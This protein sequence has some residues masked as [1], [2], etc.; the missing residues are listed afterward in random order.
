LNATLHTSILTLFQANL[1]A[2]AFALLRPVVETLYRVHLVIMGEP[3][4]LTGLRT[5]KF[6]LSF[7]RD[8]QKIDDHFSLGGQ[9]K[10]LV[11][12]MVSLLHSFT[13]V[14]RE[15][16]RRQFNGSN[17]EANYPEAEILGVTGMSMMAKFMIATRIIERFQP[18]A[19]QEVL[20]LFQGFSLSLT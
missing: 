2:G 20:A 12:R 11:D 15:Q 18:D 5:D 13:H 10:S 16:V 8:A 3:E 7:E 17:L 6:R 1:P 19:Q 9:F 14:G 4:V